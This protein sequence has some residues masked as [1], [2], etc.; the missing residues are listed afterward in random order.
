M[1]GGKL[2]GSFFHR[3]VVLICQ[4]DAQGALGLILNRPAE[5]TLGDAIAVDIPDKLRDETLFIGGPVQPQ[6][7]SFLHTDTFVPHANVFTN[8]NLSHSLEGLVE[9]GESYSVTQQVKVFA[10]YSGWSPGQL[11]DEMARGAWI[12][13]PANLDIVFDPDTDNLWK[14]ILREKGWQYQLLA[15]APE[16]LSWN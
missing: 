5:Q 2:A 9:L 8:L 1:D 12:T 7:L 10:G 14:K 15:H 3:A 16:D 4:H 13:H 6:A 11:E